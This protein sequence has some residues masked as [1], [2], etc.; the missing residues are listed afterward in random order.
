MIIKMRKGTERSR[1]TITFSRLKTAFGMGMAVTFVMVLSSLITF[2]V[3]HYLL[4]PLKMEYL[5]TLAFILVI[6]VLVQFVEMVL[7]KLLPSLYSVILFKTQLIS[8][9]A[10]SPT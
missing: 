4:V 3:H 5:Q 10:K 7:A 1:F 9:W 8:V 2:A 6:A